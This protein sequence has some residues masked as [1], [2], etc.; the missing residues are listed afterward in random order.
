M[1]MKNLNVKYY[2]YQLIQVL[3]IQVISY[4]N[5]ILK[6]HYQIQQFFVVFACF[7]DDKEIVNQ[8]MDYIIYYILIVED[9]VH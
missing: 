8:P 9:V 1:K 3:M 7:V 4:K 6:N 5:I 2:L